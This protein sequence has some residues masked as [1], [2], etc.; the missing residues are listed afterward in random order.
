MIVYVDTSAALKLLIDE[1]ESAPLADELTAAA[2]RGDRLISSMLLYTELHCAARRRA[3]LAPEL[4]NSV[5]NSISLVDV[6]RADL[7]Y[8]AA[9]AGGL[10]S[11]D[12]I[13]L[14]A[15][16]R[17][18]ADMLV[19]YDGELLTAAASAGLRTLAPGQG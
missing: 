18:Q 14:A 4:V 5:V 15:A 3:R 6:T 12:A 7:L 11:A 10:R 13:H 9:L 2:A 19:A 1:T 17:L 16:I 8:A